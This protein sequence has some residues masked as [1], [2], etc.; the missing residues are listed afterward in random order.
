MIGEVRISVTVC[1]GESGTPMPHAAVTLVPINPSGVAGRPALALTRGG[2]AEEYTADLNLTVPGRWRYGIH[3]AAPLG[4][5][6][7]EA[8][9]DV[10]SPPDRTDPAAGLVFLGAAAALLAGGLY[11]FAEGRRARAGPRD[12]H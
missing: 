5:G 8:A 10:R 9:L 7:A 2:R 12:R 3:V 4:E 6:A 1:E 11:L